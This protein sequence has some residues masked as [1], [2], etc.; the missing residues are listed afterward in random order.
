MFTRKFLGRWWSKALRRRVL[1]KA[2][3]EVRSE[4]VGRIIVKIL[5]VLRDALESP[6]VRRMETY[7]IERARSISKK[8]VEWGHDIAEAWSQN[9][10]FARY[11]TMLDINA[12]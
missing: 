4:D 3:D 6:F 10:G 8:A 5:A 11:L 2:F 12:S 7:G 9:L 1:F